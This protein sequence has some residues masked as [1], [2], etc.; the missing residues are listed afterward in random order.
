M[1]LISQSVL[2][3]TCA[4]LLI[5]TSKDVVFAEKGGHFGIKGKVKILSLNASFAEYCSGNQ[6]IS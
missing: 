2:D 4:V 3:L 1:F 5:A 6:F